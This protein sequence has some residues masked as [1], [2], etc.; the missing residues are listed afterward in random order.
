[1]IIDKKQLA[2]RHGYYQ[3]GDRKT[4][5]KTELMDWDNQLH[6]TWNWNYNDDFFGQA[7][8]AKEPK[9]DI[10]ELYRQ[11]ALEL[12]ATHDYLIL[13]YSG[14]HDSAQML[15]AFLENDIPIDE[16]CV[17]YS[18]YDTISNQFKE[19]SSLTWDKLKWL[20]LF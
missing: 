5:I 6:Q 3:I 9:E 1:M 15:Y 4:Y 17:Y 10:D 16:V 7:D 12:R 11:R 19:L 2:D 20:K 13:Y 8:W 18:K 14:G